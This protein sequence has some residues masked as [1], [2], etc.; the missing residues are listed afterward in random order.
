MKKH[1]IDDKL[2][3]DDDKQKERER[4]KDKEKRGVISLIRTTT[5]YNK[6]CNNGN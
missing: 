4:D 1:F 5:G 2:E 3:K 6:C